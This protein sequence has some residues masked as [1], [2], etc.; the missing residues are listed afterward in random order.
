MRKSKI[1]NG[2]C[3]VIVE[4]KVDKKLDKQAMAIASA[5]YTYIESLSWLNSQPKATLFEQETVDMGVEKPQQK[6]EDN[7]LDEF[8]DMMYSLYPTKC[9][10][11]NCSLGKSKRDKLRIK[12]LL[13]TYTPEQIEQVIRC[14]VDSNYGINYMKNFSTFLNNFPDPNAICQ[15]DPATSNNDAASKVVINGVEYK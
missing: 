1:I 3:Q 12:S 8:V 6:E 5:L 10:K 15:N 7:S 9:P 14:E 2:L 4:N 13:K 11:R